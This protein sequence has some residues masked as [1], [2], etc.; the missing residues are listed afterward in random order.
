MEDFIKQ[1]F[2]EWGAFVITGLVVFAIKDLISQLWQGAKFLLG[3]DFN[4]DDI[5][6]ING[7]KKAR[8]VRQ[9]LYKTTFYVYDHQRKFVVPNDRLWSLNIEK[10]LP[11]NKE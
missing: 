7:G 4:K 2:G 8:I 1:Y 6:Y 5:V 11:D 3:N 9:N 10:S